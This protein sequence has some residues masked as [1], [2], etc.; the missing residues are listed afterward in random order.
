MNAAVSVLLPIRN[1]GGALGECLE[2]LERQ[3]HPPA[4]IVAINDGSVDD[5]GTTLRAWQQR[6]PS[7]EIL[8]TRPAGLVAALNLGLGRCRSPLVAR[9]DA[10]DRS[11]PTRLEKQVALLASNPEVT[12]ASCGVRH[13][14]ETGLRDGFRIYDDWL[15]SLVSHEDIWRERFIE[16]PVAHPS[17][18]F[19]RH[20]VEEAGGYLDH[21]WPEDYDLWLR[22]LARGCR[23]EKVP[24]VLL[25]WR[26]TAGRL[27][28]SSPRYSVERFLECKAEHLV[29]GPLAV[30]RRLLIWGAGPTGRR[31]AKHLLRR[32][33]PLEAFIDIDPK[34]WGRTV[35]GVRVDGPDS[36][37]DPKLREVPGTILLAAVSSRG[38]RT[39]IRDALDRSGWQEAKD[40][41]V[42]A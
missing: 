24:E 31:I 40:Y 28:R 35:R 25:E 39:K 4:Q 18:M 9:M 27:T 36:L 11:L 21:H 38:A 26:D 37:D 30:C 20:A 10:D 29:K 15:N 42:V 2:S 7:L 13:F 8:E 33:A 23:F 19:R 6:L 32:H 12:V 14:A 17:V 34:K 41:W 5:T 16:S 22:L 1:G 3:T